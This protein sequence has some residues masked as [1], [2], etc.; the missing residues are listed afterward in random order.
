MKTPGFTAEAGLYTTT[1]RYQSVTRW[2]GRPAKQAVVPAWYCCLLR[3]Y[4]GG[5]VFGC[6][7]HNAWYPFASAAC[8]AE[9]YWNTCSGTLVEGTCSA[10]PEC[11]GKIW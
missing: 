5:V 9:G 8:A 3:P 7:G 6:R 11:Q 4:S 1:K 2:N 10:R